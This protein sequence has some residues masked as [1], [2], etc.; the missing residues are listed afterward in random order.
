MESMEA[1]GW[2]KDVSCFLGQRLIF[3]ET[4]PERKKPGVPDNCQVR[5]GLFDDHRLLRPTH[6][7]NLVE[8]TVADF[9][10]APLGTVGAQ[11]LANG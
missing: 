1:I 5:E 8:V 10:C 6:D 7:K 11:E 2:H 4:A 9:A 3:Q